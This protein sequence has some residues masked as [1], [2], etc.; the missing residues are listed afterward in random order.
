MMRG[1]CQ[2]QG[3]GHPWDTAAPGVEKAG[4]LEGP[5]PWCLGGSQFT[6]GGNK[7]D[8][9]GNI[10]GSQWHEPVGVSK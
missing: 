9:G 10:M 7:V 5:S 3:H 2:P 6:G 1:G 8:W 4:Q